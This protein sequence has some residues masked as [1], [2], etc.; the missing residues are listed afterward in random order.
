MFKRLD[1]ILVVVCL[2]V[3]FGIYAE[4]ARMNRAAA[5]AEF[6]RI[7]EDGLQALDS[8]M[9]IYLQSLNGAAG[10]MQASENIES[11]DFETFVE[12]VDIENY[13]PGT[14]PGPPHSVSPACPRGAPSGT[15]RIGRGPSYRAE[16]RVAAL[17]GAWNASCREKTDDFHLLINFSVD[18]LLR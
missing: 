3:T 5:K 7:T 17:D 14:L 9:N 12:S 4:G 8:R 6:A 18:H 1:L 16:P 2:L 11:D 13:L 15:F 10:M